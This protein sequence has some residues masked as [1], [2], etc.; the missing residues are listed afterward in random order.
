MAKI[1]VTKTVSAE[2]S[3]EE[4]EAVVRFIGRTSHS[5]RLEMGLTNEQSYLLENLYNILTEEKSEND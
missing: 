2:L 5:S 4:T 1:I 3:P